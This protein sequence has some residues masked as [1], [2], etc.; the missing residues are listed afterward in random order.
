MRLC[1]HCDCFATQSDQFAVA[2]HYTQKMEQWQ[3]PHVE[4]VV[5]LVGEVCVY[6]CTLVLNIS[7]QSWS[8]EHHKLLSNLRTHGFT[9]TLYSY[10]TH[11]EMRCRSM[12]THMY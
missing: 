10:T 9:P 1:V 5:S 7:L 12:T 4:L 11:L 3:L 6:V 2:L 8:K